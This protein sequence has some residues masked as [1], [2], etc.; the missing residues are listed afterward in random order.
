MGEYTFAVTDVLKE[1]LKRWLNLPPD[2]PQ[3][4]LL[5]FDIDSTLIE[6]LEPKEMSSGPMEDWGH[7]LVESKSIGMSIYLRPN[8]REF[9][10]FIDRFFTIMIWSHGDKE[11]VDYV[12]ALLSYYF[13]LERNV[14][15]RTYNR[16]DCK[17]SEKLYNPNAPK[18]LRYIVDDLNRRVGEKTFDLNDIAIVDDL[19]TTY[20]IQKDSCIFVSAFHYA[21]VDDDVFPQLIRFFE[22]LRGD[23]GFDFENS[24]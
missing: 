18:D 2:N 10:R 6:A 13:G 9:M 1:K 7:R 8:V 3:K 23:S 15:F 20:E 24:R 16:S 19:D 21:N 12:S 22:T 4:P 14:V 11:Y 17:I 5:V